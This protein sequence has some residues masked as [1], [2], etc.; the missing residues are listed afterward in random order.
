MGSGANVAEVAGRVLLAVLLAFATSAA[1]LRLLGLRRGWGSALLSGIVGWTI[2][3]GLALGL[4][5]WDWGSDGLLTHIVA[6][7]IPATMGV[8][9]GLDLL[10]RPG[11]LAAADRAGLVVAPRPI[12]AVR[13][14]IDVIRRYRELL[15]LIREQGF[16]PFL[17]AGWR[18]EKAGEPIGERLRNVLESAGGVYVKIG[19]IAATRP[20]LLPPEICAELPPSKTRR[21]PNPPRPSSRSS[22]PN[23]ADR[24]RQCFGNSTGPRWEQPRSRKRTG[25]HSIRANRSS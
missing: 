24:S 1:S 17:G 19:Q 11:S 15:G 23:S 21:T 9:V 13:E 6:I 5:R 12:R 22:S 18:A 2:G 20:D 14:R 10:A 4:S 7:S 25:R 16:G 8:A 3:A